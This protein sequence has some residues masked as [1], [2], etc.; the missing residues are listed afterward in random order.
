MIL[1]DASARWG[2]GRNREN[3]ATAPGGPTVRPGAWAQGNPWASPSAGRAGPRFPS[4]LSGGETALP[5]FRGAGPQSPRRARPSQGP[6]APSRS[7]GGGRGRRVFGPPPF[8][9]PGI[10]VDHAGESCSFFS[11]FPWGAARRVGTRRF[12]TRRS[13]GWAPLERGP[14]GPPGAGLGRLGWED[15][16]TMLPLSGTAIPAH[17]GRGRP[18]APGPN[19]P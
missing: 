3:K 4:G 18:P 5:R 9:G 19:P 11:S 15:I 13:F 1:G 14:G 10:T 17:W 8:S 7:G 6:A 2:P 16:G 12:E